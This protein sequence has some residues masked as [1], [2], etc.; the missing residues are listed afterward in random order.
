MFKPLTRLQQEK[1]SPILSRL[2]WHWL[3]EFEKYY[4]PIGSQ[5]NPIIINRFVANSFNIEYK[6]FVPFEHKWRWY[7]VSW[8]LNP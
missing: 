8:K 6:D 7:V 4:V 2:A 5:L 1:L 3:L